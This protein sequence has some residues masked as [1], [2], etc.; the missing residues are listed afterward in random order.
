VRP[1]RNA[2]PAS[3]GASFIPAAPKPVAAPTPINAERPSF[4]AD[5]PNVG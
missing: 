5:E 2:F 4:A 3:F 1:D